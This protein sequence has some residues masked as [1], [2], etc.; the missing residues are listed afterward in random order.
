M[1]WAEIHQAL[2][3]QFF[4]PVV[5]YIGKVL[6]KDYDSRVSTL[7]NLDHGVDF[8]KLYIQ[9][10]SLANDIITRLYVIWQVK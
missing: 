3:P 6:V 2:L 7:V 4:L 1:I 8:S 9:S 5:F 10:K